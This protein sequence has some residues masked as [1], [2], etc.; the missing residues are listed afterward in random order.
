MKNFNNAEQ[1]YPKANYIFIIEKRTQSVDNQ[2][3]Q[4]DMYV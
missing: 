3:E 1:R 4:I 2:Y